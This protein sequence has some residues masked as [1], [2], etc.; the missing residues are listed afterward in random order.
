M[1]EIRIVPK[2]L[3][4]PGRISR[5]K[6]HLYRGGWSCVEKLLIGVQSTRSSQQCGSVCCVQYARVNFRAL[7]AGAPHW[8]KGHLK[9]GAIWSQTIWAHYTKR[10]N[11]TL[12]DP[13][14]PRGSFIFGSFDMMLS[15]LAAK[16]RTWSAGA[17]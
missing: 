4:L 8:R 17:G 15:L 14:V 16:L 12:K 6:R 9:S 5:C 1:R 7:A 13:T 11:C 3:L 10:K 2:I